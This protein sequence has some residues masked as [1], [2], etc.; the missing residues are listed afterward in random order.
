VG[1]TVLGLT[2]TK[3]GCDIAQCGACTWTVTPCGAAFIRCAVHLAAAPGDDGGTS[4][5]AWIN[6]DAGPLILNN[7]AN[8][9]DMRPPSLRLGFQERKRSSANNLISP[10]ERL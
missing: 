2:G 9:V 4:V 5:S 8:G 1:T 3:F 6:N 10:I 7:L